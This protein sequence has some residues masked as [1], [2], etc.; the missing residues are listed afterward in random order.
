VILV[1]AEV[2]DLA[3]V[4]SCPALPV[5]AAKSEPVVGI[6]S[7]LDE[8][9]ARKTSIDR[10][11]PLDIRERLANAGL[12]LTL[13][14]R[15]RSYGSIRGKVGCRVDKELADQLL[16]EEITTEM[17]AFRKKTTGVDNTIL[18][19]AKVP[20]HMPRI[21]VALDP[22]THLDRLGNNERWRSSM[23]ASSQE[24]FRSTYTNR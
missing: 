10:A 6:N 8:V 18:I 15:V 21:K 5:E 23:G 11:L 12:V 17:P 14:A 1:V 22:P 7:T 19:P 20:R 13:S 24:S 4:R 16:E 2:F 9:Q 3:Y